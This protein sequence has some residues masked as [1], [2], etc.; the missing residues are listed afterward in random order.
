[1]VTRSKQCTYLTTCSFTFLANI[2]SSN[3]TVATQPIIKEFQV[4]QTQAGELVCFNVFLFGMGGIFW[5]P[6]MRVI[7][8]GPIYL[9]ALLALSMMDVWSSQ[10]AS[11]KE[12]LA[13]WIISGFGL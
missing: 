10:A 8:K 12:L 13:S 6:L 7:G 2:N 4:T 1:L 3:F 9:L 5:V 11:Y